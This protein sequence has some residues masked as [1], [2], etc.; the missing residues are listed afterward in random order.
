MDGA[1]VNRDR[2]TCIGV[3]WDHGSRGGTE[4]GVGYEKGEL[5]IRGRYKLEPPKNFG[6]QGLGGAEFGTHG[7]TVDWQGGG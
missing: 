6:G 3:E 5:S 1:G 7:G 2:Y 4:G